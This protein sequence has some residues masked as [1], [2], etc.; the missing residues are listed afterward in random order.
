VWG[1]RP[2]YGWVFGIPFRDRSADAPV[3][4][5]P[6]PPK[7]QQ[8]NALIARWDDRRCEYLWFEEI[9]WEYHLSPCSE[10]ET[11][12]RR[13]SGSSV[14]PMVAG[15]ELNGQPWFADGGWKKAFP[16]LPLGK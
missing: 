11:I 15:A 6:R 10:I 16:Y 1:D 3:V 7:H 5:Y 13:R 12:D 14:N 9:G 4:R 8:L 2:Q